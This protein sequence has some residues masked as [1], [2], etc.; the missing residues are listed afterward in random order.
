[1]TTAPRSAPPIFPDAPGTPSGSA[2]PRAFTASRIVLTLLCLM[3]LI[4]Y[5]D[6]VNIATAASEIRKD[7][8]LSNT[9]LG[10]VFSAFA[11]P[12]LLC[13]VMGGWIGDR[14]GPRST[15]TVCG[16]IWAAAT[17]LTG[18]AGGMASLLLVRVLLGLG[19]GATFPVATRA[20]QNWTPAERRGFAQ[21]ITHAFARFGN[22]VTPPIVAWLIALVTWRG[23]FV[24]L[25]CVSLVWV[26]VWW[27]Y[28]RDHPA[29]HS[30]VTAAEL[31][32]LPHAGVPQTATR[33]RVPWKPLVWRMLPVTIVYFCYGWT[34]WL[35]LN[36]L[37]SYFL[38]EYS[39]DIRKSALFASA[40][41]FAGVVGDLLGGS[42]SDRIL[43]RT[44]DVRKARLSVVAAGFGGSF[45]FLLPIFATRDLATITVC[46]AA[47]LFAAELVIGPMWSIPMDI[48]GRYSGTAS[49][50]MNTGSALAGVLSPLAFGVI[51]DRT[52]NWQLPFVGSLGLLLTG[53]CLAFTM[54]PE[55]P[56]DSRPVT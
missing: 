3:Y 54:H 55:R 51:V 41:F 18:L 11:Y 27:W 19:E 52:G 35:Y 34:L 47:A 26:A 20:M 29:A 36:W 12:Y 32:R 17:I 46:L 37:P 14:M 15:L 9:E 5:I 30:G 25:G 21:G 33:R 39:L 48:A 28:F 31:Q 49:G 40:V 8:G 10:L 1:V 7:L 42:I 4:T 22:A 43:E 50:L 24:A 53:L 2:H 38:H 6:R 45:V 23:S 13:Q 44:G 56:F 16:L